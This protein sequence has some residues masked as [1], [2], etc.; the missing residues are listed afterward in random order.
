MRIDDPGDGE[1]DLEPVC[2]PTNV[3]DDVVPVVIIPDDEW[4]LALAADTMPALAVVC[5]AAVVE[6]DDLI[7]GYVEE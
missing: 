2:R 3:D 5:A 1:A 7:D 4:S 6:P